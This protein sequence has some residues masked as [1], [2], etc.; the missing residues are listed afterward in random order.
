[1]STGLRWG[2][3]LLSVLGIILT[4]EIMRP[5]LGLPGALALALVTAALPWWQWALAT[6]RLPGTAQ[7]WLC[8]VP[9]AL[10]ALAGWWGL[11][12]RAGTTLPGQAFGAL[13]CALVFLPSVMVMSY[14]RPDDTA[15]SAIP[16]QDP[17]G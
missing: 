13:I 7:P 2:A 14:D 12:E 1:M 11:A 15:R 9:L 17:H 5:A 16:E 10:V 8:A 6:G 3:A 4:T